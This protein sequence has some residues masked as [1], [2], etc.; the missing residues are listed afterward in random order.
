MEFKLLFPIILLTLFSC[1]GG[2]GGGGE[3]GASSGASSSKAFFS[4]WTEQSTSNIYNMTAGS[5]N[6]LFTL[7]NAQVYIPASWLTTLSNAGRTAMPTAGS[8]YSCNY[9]MY[10]IG[11]NFNG[12]FSLDTNSNL[13]TVSNNACLLL[14][15]Q[16]TNGTVCNIS[17]DHTYSISNGILTIDWFT[18][19]DSGL[20]GTESYE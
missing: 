18:N 17:A 7:F 16:C 2:G 8:Y 12:V 5:F 15:S 14:D 6:T 11:D 10:V 9:L 19:S 13:D 4:V 20:Y 3:S 1:G